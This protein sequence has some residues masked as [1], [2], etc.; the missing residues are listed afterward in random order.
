MFNKQQDFLGFIGLGINLDHFANK[1]AKFK[2]DYGF[3]LYFVDSN[4]DVTLSSE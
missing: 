2:R 4:N 3:E 1:F